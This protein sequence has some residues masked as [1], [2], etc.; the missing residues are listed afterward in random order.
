MGMGNRVESE[1]IS[2]MMH[3]NERCDG[4]YSQGSR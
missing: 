4:E 1:R 2:H 3:K